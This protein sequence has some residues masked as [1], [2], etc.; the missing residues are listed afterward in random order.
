MRNKYLEEK[1]PASRCGGGYA[2]H[3]F[4]AGMGILRTVFLIA[5]AG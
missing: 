3:D 4:L 5:S 2:D 1:N